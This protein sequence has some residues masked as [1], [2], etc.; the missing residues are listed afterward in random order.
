[1]SNRS[2]HFGRSTNRAMSG[3]T[4]PAAH[5]NRPSHFVTGRGGSSQQIAC[6]SCNHAMVSN[7]CSRCHVVDPHMGEPPIVLSGSDD[8]DEEVQL[9][10]SQS[11]FKQPLNSA[12]PR[13][14]HKNNI[15]SDASASKGGSQEVIVLDDEEEPV[16]P[17]KRPRH[18]KSRES[19]ASVVSGSLPTN[20]ASTSAPAAEA[21]TASLTALK[22]ADSSP[23]VP[24]RSAAAS[25][26]STADNSANGGDSGSK[27]V[28]IAKTLW[29]GTCKMGQNVEVT[30]TSDRLEWHLAGKLVSVP[31]ATVNAFE[32]DKYLGAIGL[33]SAWDPPA[34]VADLL[35]EI[36][37]GG[38][39]PE[40]ARQQ[41]ES[42]IYL[43]YDTESFH[44]KTHVVTWPSRMVQVSSKLKQLASFMGPGQITGRHSWRRG[45]GP[46]PTVQ[47]TKEEKTWVQCDRCDKW[48]CVQ[49][50][51]IPE[52]E[53]VEWF[54]EMNSTHADRASCEAPCDWGFNPGA[55][56]FSTASSAAVPMPDTV[57]DALPDAPP[58]A[59][60]DPTHPAPARG[61]LPAS[62]VRATPRNSPADAD[63][64]LDRP[65]YGRYILVLSEYLRSLSREP[66]LHGAPTTW[67]ITATRGNELEAWGDAVDK[68]KS[69]SGR[70]CLRTKLLT[71][72]EVRLRRPADSESGAVGEYEEAEDAGGV[73]AEF[74]ANLFTKCFVDDIV[75]T[76]MELPTERTVTLESGNEVRL[77]PL[78][79]RGDADGK[80]LPFLPTV[81]SMSSWPETAEGQHHLL[82]LRHVGVALLKC[83]IDGQA[84]GPELACF[85][86]DFLLQEFRPLHVSGGEYNSGAFSSS[87]AAAEVL[88]DFVGKRADAILVACDESSWG[89]PIDLDCFIDFGFLP[90][91]KE[92]VEGGVGGG[93]TITL[94]CQAD[95]DAFLLRCAKHTLMDS[96]LLALRA[97]REGFEARGFPRGNE[98]LV[99][100]AHLSLFT[101][102]EASELLG[103]TRVI[104]PADLMR[105]IR[106]PDE[107]EAQKKW[108]QSPPKVTELLRSWLQGAA[109]ETAEERNARCFQ[110]FRCVTARVAVPDVRRCDIA[111]EL[112]VVEDKD[113]N[114]GG[115]AFA[116][117]SSTCFSLLKLPAYEESAQ[118]ERGMMLMLE[119]S[120]TKEGAFSTR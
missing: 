88:R 105:M 18:G 15:R 106:W 110:V 60:S 32:V 46:S 3:G 61:T 82:R 21:P 54:C 49:S 59:A 44:R 2:L 70:A 1:M 57:P 23:P 107:A 111:I 16:V 62:E 28:L 101:P 47:S 94:T 115:P 13:A 113:G 114:V 102:R 109:D 95:A 8:D 33:W 31:M 63:R 104:E 99:I 65:E 118:L 75:V 112:G 92:D 58:V 86:F 69:K 83:L 35:R 37:G 71:Q 34:E 41:A 5:G 40:A 7:Q 43:E 116:C 80:I 17:P 79:E 64:V 103:G 39:R 67:K 38:W 53:S 22:S 11:T 26:N 85:A 93:E 120:N 29:L 12:A 100:S 6:P 51:D 78:F 10:Q 77:F 48:R 91:H 24:P 97:F 73:T 84:V 56:A 27:F 50:R 117:S 45:V 96:R 30:F 19:G 81:A 76:G 72:T 36:E 55:A 89:V 52:D 108:K 66:V 98:D 74:F 119:Q 25:S 68:I 9:S 42:S 90:S 4:P 14:Q 87:A 20:A